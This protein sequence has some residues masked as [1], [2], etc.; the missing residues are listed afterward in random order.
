MFYKYTVKEQDGKFTGFVQDLDLETQE[1]S[2]L[3]EVKDALV[4][5]LSAYV[6]VQF[7]RQKLPIPLPSEEPKEGD[8]VLYVPVRLQLRILLWN[9]MLKKRYRQADLAKMLGVSRAQAQMYVNGSS[10]VSVESY[11]KA[12]KA[13]DVFPT[14]SLIDAEK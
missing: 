14:V 7:R 12:L 9:T 2:S 11:E 3:E 1:L 5:G 8:K 10:G 6:E 13:M 4:K